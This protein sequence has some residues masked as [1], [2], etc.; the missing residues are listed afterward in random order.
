MPEAEALGSS[1]WG[2]YRLAFVQPG[3]AFTALLS[4]RSP[5][6]WGA[7]AFAIAAA[8]YLLVYFFL[9]NNGGRPTVFTPWLRI[10]EEVY[11]RYNL[12]LVLPSI[13]LSWVSASGFTQL[14]ARALGGKGSFENTAAVLGLGIG[15]ASLS[16]GLH[17]VVTTS[18]G[19]LGF[20][21]QRA[22]EDAMSTPGTGPNYLINSLMVLYLVAFAGLFTLGVKYSQRLPNGKAFATGTVG[23][24][25][26]QAVF[27]LFNR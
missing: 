22:Y 14:L 13:L 27:V 7:M 19:Y 17:D 20:L 11:Y 12:V 4:A 8:N 15:V 9:A 26:Y 3:R 21:D 5:L 18:L 16:T 1:F 2:T 23:F 10:P 25:V 6:R 24:V